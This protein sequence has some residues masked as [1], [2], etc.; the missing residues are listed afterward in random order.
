M[1]KLK[2]IVADDGSAVLGI[3]FDV[4]GMGLDPVL[5]FNYTRLE[6]QAKPDGS[7]WDEAGA[8]LAL[9]NEIAAARAAFLAAV[10]GWSEPKMNQGE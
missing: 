7:V 3:T 5:S 4:S 9:A 1:D 8:V 6:L 2:L 10:P